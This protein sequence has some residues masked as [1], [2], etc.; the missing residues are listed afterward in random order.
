MV[1]FDLRTPE[2]KVMIVLKLLLCKVELTAISFALGVTEET[3]LE[4]L[5]RASEK[6]DEINQNL[7]RDAKVTQVEL[8]E[9]WNFVLR[10]RSADVEAGGESPEGGNE[11]RQ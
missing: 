11:G 8:D 1:F 4:W 10:K 3:S 5:R 6:A 2:E 9:L 7:L